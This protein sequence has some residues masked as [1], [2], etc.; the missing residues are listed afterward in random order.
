MVNN[1]VSVIMPVYNSECFI[2]EAILSVQA[3]TY[4]YWE[5]II[6]D[7]GS[8][9]GSAMIAE[10]YAGRDGRIRLFRFQKSSGMPAVPR[11]KG[12]QEARGRYIAFLDSDDTW[13]PDKLQ[14]QVALFSNADTVIVYSDY[15]KIPENGTRSNRIVKAPA[16][17]SYGDLLKGNVIGNLTGI[18]DVAKVGKMMF[19]LIH[20][21]DYAMWLS[22]LKKGG[23]ARNTNTVT[24]LYRVRKSSVSSKKF[25]LLFWQWNIY[26]N[27]EKLGLWKSFYYYANYA[28]R[29][30]YKSL[31]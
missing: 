14:Q 11:N 5:L 17:S 25:V 13:L 27:V 24:A 31:I 16:S 29:A 6:V 4:P 15:E 18:Y 28:C 21:E 26:R 10:R 19:R 9:D 2:E 7:D 22:I 8:T 1:M 30:L 23:V 12:I 3:Q 20:H